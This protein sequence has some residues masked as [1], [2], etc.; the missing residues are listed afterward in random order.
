MNCWWVK[1]SL[2]IT[3]DRLFT[4]LVV[5]QWLVAVKVLV[6]PSLKQIT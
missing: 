5:K 6:K 4:G 3:S 2:E 1:H